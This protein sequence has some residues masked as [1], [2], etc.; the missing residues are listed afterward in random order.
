MLGESNAASRQ[1]AQR[2]VKCPFRERLGDPPSESQDAGEIELAVPC[3]IECPGNRLLDSVKEGP[4]GIT[5]REQ[6]ETRIEA[7]QSGNTRKRQIGADRI[8]NRWAEDRR[9]AEDRLVDVIESLSR[10]TNE[11]LHLLEIA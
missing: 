5:F 11:E 7:E 9:K 10:L 8:L 1:S 6:L 4:E 3:N 2:R